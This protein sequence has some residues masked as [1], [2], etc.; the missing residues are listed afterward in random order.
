MEEFTMAI[1]KYSPTVFARYIAD[2]N[3]FVKNGGGFGNGNNP[4][5]QYD[6]EGYDS[7]VNYCAATGFRP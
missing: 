4:E 3:W 2:E 7:Y 1:G 6:N 5:S